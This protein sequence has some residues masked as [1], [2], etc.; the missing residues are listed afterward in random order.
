MQRDNTAVLNIPDY[1]DQDLTKA[2]CGC[3]SRSVS[4]IQNGEVGARIWSGRWLKMTRVVLIGYDCAF[5]KNSSRG[6]R[7][8]PSGITVVRNKGETSVRYSRGSRRRGPK[9]I[10]LRRIA[11]HR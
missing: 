7:Y 10:A 2:S 9:T 4:V 1:L 6:R 11:Q 5:E 8:D 3:N